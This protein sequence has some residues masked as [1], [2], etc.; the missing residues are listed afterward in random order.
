MAG[1]YANPNMYGQ[2][3]NANNWWYWNMMLANAGNIGS[4]KDDVS[5]TIVKLENLDNVFDEATGK[6]LK[7]ISFTPMGIKFPCG[8]V[9]PLPN[10]GRMDIAFTKRIDAMVA[11]PENAF[12]KDQ[13]IKAMNARLAVNY[14]KDNECSPFLTDTNQIIR[15]CHAWVTDDD[16]TSQIG[17]EDRNRGIGDR[18]LVGLPPPVLSRQN[19]TFS[20]E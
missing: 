16:I 17:P 10:P 19:A 1:Y 5:M 12:T 2:N 20:E 15:R 7:E 18:S 11:K 4:K 14:Y 13:A 9:I 6:K 8:V 3:V